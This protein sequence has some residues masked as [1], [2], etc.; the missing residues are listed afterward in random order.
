MGMRLTTQELVGKWCV[1][2]TRIG[3]SEVKYLG[4]FSHPAI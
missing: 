4:P 1:V 3:A 2:E